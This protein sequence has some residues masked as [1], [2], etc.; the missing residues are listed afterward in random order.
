MGPGGGQRP[1]GRLP[2]DDDDVGAT[3]L[4][5]GAERKSTWEAGAPPERRKWEKAETPASV[6]ETAPRSSRLRRSAL[7]AVL[8]PANATATAAAIDKWE[9]VPIGDAEMKRWRL[10]MRK[11]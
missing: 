1:A 11:R 9:A 3:E 10:T 8:A 5:A 2:D 6:D 4:D 7:G